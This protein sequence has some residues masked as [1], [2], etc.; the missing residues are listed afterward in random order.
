MGSEENEK[1]LHDPAPLELTVIGFVLAYPERFYEVLELRDQ[2]FAVPLHRK[3]FGALKSLYD[4]D[5]LSAA[6]TPSLV[7]EKLTDYGVLQSESFA[8]FTRAMDF[9]PAGPDAIVAVKDRLVAKTL[10]EAIG[11]LGNELVEAA[12]KRMD[13]DELT[14]L[15][16]SKLG[17]AL[18]TGSTLNIKTLT[19]LLDAEV[20]RMDPDTPD[21]EMGQSTG[22]SDLDRQ[23]SGIHG[24]EVIVIAGR[25]SM[26]KSSLLN[27]LAMSLTLRGVPGA[28]FSLE[29]RGAEYAQRLL[30]TRAA[31][32]IQQ[33]RLRVLGQQ[34][35]ADY[36]AA[37]QELREHS[38][39]LFVYDEGSISMARISSTVRRLS[40][41]E[42]VQWVG[43]DYLQLLEHGQRRNESTNDAIGRSSRAAKSLAL[44][45]DVPVDADCVI[46]LHRPEHYHQ[47]DEEWAASHPDNVGVA[48]LIVAKQ[49]NGPIG[50]VKVAWNGSCAAFSDYRHPGAPASSYHEPDLLGH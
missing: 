47:G 38:R 29:M 18:R 37:V 39:K 35:R 32:D 21:A 25:P 44:S 2:H 43:V 5:G 24:G 45:L 28:I 49:R 42:G 22:L 10:R 36:M 16:Q 11:N 7:A 46:L 20:V 30:C 17:E 26:G 13:Q 23:I 31:C 33:A 8:L 48:E 6:S 12:G 34:Q 50:T 1:Q 27:H 9:A 14:D 41:E 4:D 40:F 15:A 3:V 19:E